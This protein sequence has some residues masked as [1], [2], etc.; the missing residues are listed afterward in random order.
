MPK[1]FFHASTLVSKA[2]VGTIAKCGS[3]GLYKGCQ[4]PKMPY[5][6]KGK[7]GVLIVGEFPFQDEDE[8][9][10]HFTSE[11]GQ[12]LR[13]S[14]EEIGVDM[15]EDCWLTNA[16]ICHA[17]KGSKP[18][19][20]VEYCRPNLMRT[21]AELKPHTVILLGHM[22]VKAFIGAIWKEDPGKMERWAGWAI[23]CQ[24]P[25]VWIHPMYH[26]T[27][28]L[29]FDRKELIARAFKRH[30]EAAF[31]HDSKPW[32][33]LPDYRSNVDVIMDPDEAARIIDKMRE[34]G[35]IIASDYENNCLKPETPGAQ[36]VCC[37]HSWRGRKTI[38][39]PW[40]GDAVRASRDIF[41]ADNCRHIASNLKHE[42]RWTL[43]DS[44][45]PVRHWYLDTMIAAHAL[46]N[47]PG[48]CG[49]KFQAFV[50]LGAES[51]DDAI[52]KFLAPTGD[53]K[54]NRVTSEV[55]VPQ[56]LLYCA[57]D[58]LLEYLLAAVQVFEMDNLGE[59]PEPCVIESSLH[60]IALHKELNLLAE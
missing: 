14:L 9:G 29:K 11:S 59:S 53:K 55:N 45:R 16:I 30:L 15:R 19:E 26:P 1:G 60:A 34:K 3:C 50:R 2:P 22:A 36:I 6:G 37:S 31:K 17:P 48:I 25:N 7:R 32:T 24:K 44:G 47:R 33:K 20:K 40:L 8:D 46:D 51:Y 57:M 13:Q 21:F 35:G 27:H 41:H 42:N 23:P 56:L 49:L 4:S 5:S 28:V 10:K 52:K 12:Y 58:T 38:A 39:F 18:E 54:I 43:W